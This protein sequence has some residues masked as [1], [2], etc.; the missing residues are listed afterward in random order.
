MFASLANMP[1]IFHRF[2]TWLCSH[3]YEFRALIAQHN[4]GLIKFENFQ[5]VYYVFRLGSKIKWFTPCAPAHCVHC[6]AATII[7]WNVVRFVWR[8][9]W[10]D[11]MVYP[12]RTHST[13]VPNARAMITII[14]MMEWKSLPPQ[15]SIRFEWERAQWPQWNFYNSKLHRSQRQTPDN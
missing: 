9:R 4:M 15:T 6:S 13:A 2:H 8:G 5:N 14:I 1:M 3:V 11:Y 7:L 10:F 12:L